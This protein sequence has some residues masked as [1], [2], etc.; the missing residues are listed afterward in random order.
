MSQGF[1][2]AFFGNNRER[3]K[4]L[5]TG[6]APIVL[7]AH[8][9]LQRNGDGEYLFRQDSSFWYLTGI[10]VPGV[11]LVLDKGK[12]YLIVPDRDAVVEAFDG[13]TDFDDLKHV[14][15]I[16]EVL[17][18]KEGWKRLTQRVKKVRHIATLAPPPAYLER[19]GLYTNPARARL[20]SNL[21]D[22]N[23]SLELLDLRPHLVRMRSVKQPPE[24][25]AIQ[26]AIDITIAAFKKVERKLSKYNFEYEIEA[27][28]SRGFRRKGALGHAYSPVVAGGAN[29]CTLHHSASA[30]LKPGPLYI[31]AGAEYQHYAADITR[32]YFLG[33]A[34][35]R[36]AKVYQAVLDV[37]AFAKSLLKPGVKIREYEAEVEQFMGEK[38]RELGVIKLIEKETVRK[39]FPHA[40][41]HSLGLDTHDVMDYERPLEAGMVLTVEPGI[42]IPEEGLGV[43]VE[44]DILITKEGIKILS[45]ALPVHLLE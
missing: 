31:D 17:G 15:G 28:L 24:L 2:A 26:T 8:G 37:Q 11:I 3:L 23:K 5:F 42:Y 19:F 12:E 21:K 4:T 14:S 33:G 40:T 1:D 13:R 34:T 27:D 32:T 18:E 35:K 43:R 7:T 6:K 36:Q 10:D 41:S 30:G 38:L 22:T 39:Y 29:T 25:E 16:E 20:I 9:L 44:D 45:D